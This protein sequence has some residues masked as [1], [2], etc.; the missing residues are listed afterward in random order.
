MLDQAWSMLGQAWAFLSEASERR[1]KPTPWPRYAPPPTYM[2][3]PHLALVM[4]HPPAPL[5][6]A[7]RPACRNPHPQRAKKITLMLALMSKCNVQKRKMALCV[8]GGGRGGAHGGVRGGAGDSL[9]A[10]PSIYPLTSP[11]GVAFRAGREARLQARLR[12]NYGN[13]ATP[14]PHTELNSIASCGWAGAGIRADTASLLIMPRPAHVAFRA[15]R[16]LASLFV[17]F[18]PNK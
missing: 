10:H 1:T 16:S 12:L 17:S 5:P 8:C 13:N 6:P 4:V 18:F 3:H 7:A 11:G 14:T 9:W 2:A 15:A